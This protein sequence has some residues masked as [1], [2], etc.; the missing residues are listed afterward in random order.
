MLSSTRATCAA[1]GRWTT[2]LGSG[3]LTLARSSSSSLPLHA[4]AGRTSSW[5]WAAACSG[6]S[7]RHCQRCP[8][9]AVCGC[10]A[11]RPTARAGA[12]PCR[13]PPAC[14]PRV[15]SSWSCGK[16]RCTPVRMRRASTWRALWARCRTGATACARAWRRCA[17]RLARRGACEA[18]V[19]TRRSWAR[20]TFAF[21]RMATRAR[22]SRSG[23]G[24]CRVASLCC[25]KSPCLTTTVTISLGTSWRVAAAA[26]RATPAATLTARAC[27]QVVLTPEH[28]RNGSFLDALAAVP[29]QRLAAMRRRAAD[30]MP[31][32]VY[33]G[34][35]FAGGDAVD[36]AL[37]GVWAEL[38]T[39]AT[40]FSRH[41]DRMSSAQRFRR[42]VDVRPSRAACA[43]ARLADDRTTVNWWSAGGPHG[44]W[45]T[46]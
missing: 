9:F 16:R 44:R 32:Y 10:S 2:A 45:P 23:T 12:S 37:R 13:I 29:R 30:A 15:G 19:Q 43:M 7:A 17:T 25:S 22:A 31:R 39:P 41:L 21:S 28:M 46:G 36:H 34:A 38:R 5:C 4:P 40:A 24:C 8:S 33:G 26:A 35:G 20:A 11:S 14:T 1:R 42:H 18:T 27:S 3:L 6:S